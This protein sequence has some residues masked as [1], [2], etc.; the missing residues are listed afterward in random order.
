MP[1]A[2]AQSLLLPVSWDYFEVQ[3]D[4]ATAHRLHE[5]SA[6]ALELL[7]QALEWS[8]DHPGALHFLI[9]VWEMAGDPEVLCMCLLDLLGA[10]FRPKRASQPRKYDSTMSHLH[11]SPQGRAAGVPF[12]DTVASRRGFGLGHLQHMPSHTYLR[13]GRYSDAVDVNIAAHR[14]DMETAAGCRLPYAPEHNLNMLVYASS[15]A[16]WLSTALVRNSL[17]LAASIA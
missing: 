3:G 8:P 5:N 4:T 15:M 2:A 6:R 1:T 10:A 17:P 16:G 12:A 9:H 13:V 14:T 11:A 7:H